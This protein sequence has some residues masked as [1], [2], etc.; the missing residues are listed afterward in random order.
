RQFARTRITASLGV[1]LLIGTVGLLSGLWSDPLP[2]VAW[3]AALTALHLIITL[4][5]RKFL[6]A[7]DGA[8]RLR[9][10]RIRFVTFDF[11]LGI[12]WMLNVVYVVNGEDGH[13]FMLAVM[14]LVIAVSS[15][16]ASS[17]PV[18]VFAATMPV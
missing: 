18:A 5:C 6:A 8:E 2:A 3:T 10:W 17:L 7:P 1:L 13:T 11:L 4:Q 15:M 9:S 12:T 16:L 14:L